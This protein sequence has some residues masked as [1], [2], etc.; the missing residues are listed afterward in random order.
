MSDQYI[1]Q[2]QLDQQSH[3][4]SEPCQ[5]VLDM[6]PG[7]LKDACM[8]PT[9]LPRRPWTPWAP[10][11]G[12]SEAGLCLGPH[13]AAAVQIPSCHR[14]SETRLCASAQHVKR[15]GAACRACPRHAWAWHSLPWAATVWPTSCPTF[16]TSFGGHMLGTC[17]TAVMCCASSKDPVIP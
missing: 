11:A 15:S 2:Q 16:A 9:H 5:R 6:G 3:V 8:L 17:A 13:N 4:L 14:P 12:L 7:S 1:G 10:A